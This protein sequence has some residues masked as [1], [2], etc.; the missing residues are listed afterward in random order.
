RS[1]SETYGRSEQYYLNLMFAGGPKLADTPR[2]SNGYNA[3]L[4]HLAEMN[5]D[6]ADVVELAKENIEDY[7]NLSRAE[8][9]ELRKALDEHKKSQTHGLRLTQKGR[10]KDVSHTCQKIEDLITGAQGRCGVDGFYCIFRNTGDYSMKPRWW[11]SN[12]AID[13]YL[14]ASVRK[15]EPEKIGVLAEAFAISGANYFCKCESLS[16]LVSDLTNFG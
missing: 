10:T 11:F 3:R 6:G 2:K 4:H 5:Q 1:L 14:R 7:H 13:E 15:F 8:K 9:E 12:Q 16:V